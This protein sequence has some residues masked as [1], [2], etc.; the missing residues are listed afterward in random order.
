MASPDDSS[1]A[2]AIRQAMEGPVEAALRDQVSPGVLHEVDE[3]LSMPAVGA[4]ARAVDPIN[5]AVRESVDAAVADQE[6]DSSGLPPS[7]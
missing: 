5:L 6:S 2:D 3:A 4:V 7:D 1:V